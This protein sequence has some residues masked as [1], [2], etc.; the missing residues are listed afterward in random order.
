[1]SKVY[2]GLGTNL[3]NKEENLHAAVQLIEKQ[4]G[5]VI[6][7]SAFYATAPW[8]FHSDNTF[9]NAAACVETSLSPMEVLTSTQQIERDM[10]RTKKSAG[11]VYSDRLIDIDIL[12][13][14]D[15][16]MSLPNLVVPHPLM[17]QRDFVMRTLAEIAP[18]LMHPTLHK[19]IKEL[20][21]SLGLQSFTM[22][23]DKS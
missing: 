3:G 22:R 16:C 4:I 17:H 2:L 23:K 10:G 7:L 6:S 9:L 11:G 12:L 14:D 5:K 13:Y 20:A 19:T 18:D 1:M 21:A 8:G 15:L